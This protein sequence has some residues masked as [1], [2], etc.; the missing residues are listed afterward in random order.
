M[1]RRF[2][3]AGLAS[4]ATG[5]LA[6][7]QNRAGPPPAPAPPRRTEPIPDAAPAPLSA[8]D[9]ADLARL[10]AYL[11]GI[12]TLTARFVQVDARGGTATGRLWLSRPGRMRFEY[13]PP[14]PILLVADGTFVIF[15]DRS[16]MQTTHI[17]LGTTPL[18]LLLAERIRL[19][20]GRGADRSG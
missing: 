3:L 2:L 13:D 11:D 6:A 14:S 12:R 20:E 18:S 9:R 4:L 10:E 17:P 16:V 5:Q 19:D 8:A 15:H 1:H 7:Q